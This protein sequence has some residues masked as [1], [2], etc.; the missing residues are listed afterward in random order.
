MAR[1]LNPILARR[2]LNAALSMEVDEEATCH[3]FGRDLEVVENIEGCEF[4]SEGDV[5]TL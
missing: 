3:E 1:R 4:G 5:E 2:L